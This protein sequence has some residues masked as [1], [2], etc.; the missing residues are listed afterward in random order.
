MMDYSFN[1]E[2]AVK[3]GTDNAIM[4]RFFQFWISTNLANRK[5]QF[6]GRTWTYNTQTAL[7]E[8]M[9]FWSRRQI[10]RIMS[11]LIEKEVLL[12]GNY[13]KMK[14]DQT[15]WYA[16]KNEDEFVPLKKPQSPEIAKAPNGAMQSTKRCNDKAPNGATI[17]S[18]IPIINTYSLNVELV[19]DFVE[20]RKAMKSPMTDKSLEMFCKKLASFVADG[21]DARELVENAIINN[22]KTVYTTKDSKRV[23]NN[24]VAKVRRCV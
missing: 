18:Y 16:F 4:I 24:M 11:N 3:Y 17:T 13:N 9:P 20:N 19:M 8:L 22:W 12:S 6:D 5:N 1:V 23:A 21:Y 14:N 10:Q 2:H 7:S 15:L